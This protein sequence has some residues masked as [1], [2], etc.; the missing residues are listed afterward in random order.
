M[1]IARR[2]FNDLLTG[3]E[4]EGEISEDDLK[5]FLAK[6]QAETDSACERVDEVVKA[7]EKEILEV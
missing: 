3:R 4:K 2:E 1:R 5:R 6:V 7:K